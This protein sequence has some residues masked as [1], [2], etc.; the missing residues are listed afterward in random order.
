MLSNEEIWFINSADT[1]VY[2]TLALLLIVCLLVI[3]R[4][5]KRM[6]TQ[7]FWQL[8]A[9]SVLL[10]SFACGVLLFIKG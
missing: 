1:I 3:S 10:I 9:T 4:L 2:S 6:S 8:Y 7:Q 5:L